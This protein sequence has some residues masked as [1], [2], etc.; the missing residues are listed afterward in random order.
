MALRFSAAGPQETN[1]TPAT[2]VKNKENVFIGSK[3][4][5]VI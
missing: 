3:N 2:N 1:A 5:K 4:K